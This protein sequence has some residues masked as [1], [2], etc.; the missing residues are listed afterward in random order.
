MSRPAVSI[1]ISLLD[2]EQVAYQQNADTGKITLVSV[3]CNG[4]EELKRGE[5]F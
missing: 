4:E 1:T 2:Q 5:G 3:H